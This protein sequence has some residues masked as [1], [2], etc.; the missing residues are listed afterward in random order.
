MINA[1]SSL[2]L[3]MLHFAAGNRRHQSGDLDW[4]DRGGEHRRHTG[5]VEYHTQNDWTGAIYLLFISRLQF[6]FICNC[7]QMPTAL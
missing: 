7:R 4:F 3:C 5:Q 2:Q 6:P 1:E